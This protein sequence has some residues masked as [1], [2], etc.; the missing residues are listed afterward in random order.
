MKFSRY[1]SNFLVVF[2]LKVKLLRASQAGTL[3]ET[4]AHLNLGASRF[5]FGWISRI[6]RITWRLSGC[7]FSCSH[8]FLA[9]D[10]LSTVVRRAFQREN[11][12][13]TPRR[14]PT[15]TLIHVLRRQHAFMCGSHIVFLQIL[16]RNLA[17][18]DHH[19]TTQL[20]HTSHVST[21]A[22]A[23]NCNGW[24]CGEDRIVCAV[25]PRF[26]PH[27]FAVICASFFTQVLRL[28]SPALPR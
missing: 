8:A 23:R 1:I 3:S 22:R 10:C 11:I 28:D 9:S 12:S 7:R 2:S 6:G 17:L 26:A 20:N 25:R 13:E 4:P 14:T 24:F 27:K 5:N 18:F 21:A 19:R 15:C 16:S